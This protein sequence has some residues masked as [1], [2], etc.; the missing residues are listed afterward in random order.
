VGA[1][2]KELEEEREEDAEEDDAD[3]VD[4]ENAYCEK[5]RERASCERRTVELSHAWR[6]RPKF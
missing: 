1:D 3:D 6:S 5:W 2:A 4:E